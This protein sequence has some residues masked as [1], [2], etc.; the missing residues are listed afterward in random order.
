MS[1]DRSVEPGLKSACREERRE[2]REGGTGNVEGWRVD[3]AEGWSEG[4]RGKERG[5]RR[6]ERGEE[7]KAEHPP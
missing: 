4:E 7:D 5:W 3:G 2:E 6:A 1:N